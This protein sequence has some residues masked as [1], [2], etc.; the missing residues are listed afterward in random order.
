MTVKLIQDQIYTKIVT[1]SQADKK[2]IR[3]AIA[4][5]PSGYQFMPAYRNSNWDGYIS[6]FR[7]SKFPSGLTQMVL[8]ELD[9]QKIEWDLNVQIPF[10]DT[11]PLQ[12]EFGPFKMRD[13]QEAAASVALKEQRGIIKVATAGGKTLIITG[14]VNSVDT[15][16]IVVPTRALLMQT[17]LKL[18]E[19]MHDRIIGRYGDNFKDVQEITICTMAS[20]GR[21]MEKIGKNGRNA[22][23]ALIFDECH[24]N[25][26]DSIAEVART[27]PAPIRIGLSGTP[28]SRD[29]LD[30]MTIMGITGDIIYEATSSDLIQEGWITKPKIFLVEILEPESSTSAYDNAYYEC[31]VE[32]DIRNDLIAT[33]AKREVENG[34][35]MILVERIYHTVILQRLLPEAGVATGKKGNATLVLD[36]LRNGTLNIAIAT[37]VF[38]EGVDVPDV[39]TVIIAGGGKSIRSVLQKVGRALRKADGKNEAH[40]YDFIDDTNDHLFN[41]SQLRVE[42][43]EEEGFE[44]VM[45]DG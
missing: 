24:H 44:M 10:F 39:S 38:G 20:F 17:Y 31:I 28:M 16:V 34:P 26:A 35:V 33:I 11:R 29:V 8:D 23:D 40:I 36:E 3:N 42:I 25:K 7:Y 37:T 15:A 4:C 9:K 13:Y 14:I 2:V 45:W 30:N 12:T 19:V 41:H 32:N 43:Y 6:F 1:A 5:R 27:I 18:Q 21:M 22:L